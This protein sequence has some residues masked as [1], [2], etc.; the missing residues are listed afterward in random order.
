MSK[1]VRTPDNEQ[2][3]KAQCV[4][5]CGEILIHNCNTPSSVGR[6]LLHE[7][8]K[9]MSNVRTTHEKTIGKRS[10]K[11]TS[12]YFFEYTWGAWTYKYMRVPQ[13][14]HEQFVITHKE[15]GDHFG[16]MRTHVMTIA[17]ELINTAKKLATNELELEEVLEKFDK[18]WWPFL[19]VRGTF[20]K[21]DTF[22]GLLD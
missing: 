18:R 16:D 9:N 11:S 3:N 14:G 15:M 2:P 19:L 10:G 17:N 13:K 22:E 5:T 12:R 8:D 20:T 1:R 7:F 21:N 6:I 4:Q